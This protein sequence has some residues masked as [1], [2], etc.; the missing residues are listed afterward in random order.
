[1]EETMNKVTISRT[2]L[3][4]TEQKEIYELEKELLEAMRTVNPKVKK[5]ITVKFYERLFTSNARTL[6]KEN[7]VEL[8]DRQKLAS[9]ILDKQ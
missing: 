5:Y 2:N 1:M 4:K 9:L 6:A 7:N 8:I 3:G